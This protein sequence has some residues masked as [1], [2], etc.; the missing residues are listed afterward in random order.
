[1]TD[2]DKIIAQN[3]DLKLLFSDCVNVNS[4]SGIYDA[5]GNRVRLV[6]FSVWPKETGS[7]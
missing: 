1:M 5:A 4:H 7:F 3:I 2:L 6:H